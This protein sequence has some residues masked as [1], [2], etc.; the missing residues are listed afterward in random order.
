MIKNIF[1]CWFQGFD[2]APEIVKNCL[3]SWYHY[4]PDWNIIEID[5]NSLKKYMN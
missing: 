2:N 1:I 3:K 4:N 5:D